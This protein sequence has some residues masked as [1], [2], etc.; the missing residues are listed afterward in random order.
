LDVLGLILKG[1]PV[2]FAGKGFWG[3]GTGPAEIPRV[4]PCSSVPTQ[5]VAEPA[6]QVCRCTC[7]D[8]YLQVQKEGE[9]K[10]STEGRREK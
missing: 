10:T 5:G 7:Y 8:K 9:K 1:K 3:T 6:P 2:G 4:Y